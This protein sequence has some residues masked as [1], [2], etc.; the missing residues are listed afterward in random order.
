MTRVRLK[1]PLRAKIH[2]D[3]P[4]PDGSSVV[5]V[6]LFGPRG[7]IVMDAVDEPCDRQAGAGTDGRLVRILGASIEQGGAAGESPVS[8]GGT[9]KKSYRPEH[10]ALARW[11]LARSLVK[12]T[13]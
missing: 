12:W 3:P 1:M 8:S 2:V 5:Q 13:R 7:V 4:A 6:R 10:I 9:H 11:L